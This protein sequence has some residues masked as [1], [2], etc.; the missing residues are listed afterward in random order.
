MFKGFG[1]GW[2]LTWS[3]SD[4]REKKIGFGSDIWEKTGPGSEPRKKRDPIFT[5][6]LAFYLF[7][8]VPTS[9]QKLDSDPTKTPGSET[10]LCTYS[11]YRSCW[12]HYRSFL[13]C[14]REYSYLC[15]WSTVPELKKSRLR[16]PCSLHTA[17]IHHIDLG[18]CLKQIG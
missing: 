1:S 6:K 18:K 4:I 7:L 3:G 9:F 5:N 14:S 10:L 12:S 16:P 13:I 2:V 8:P 17:I 15:A 11:I